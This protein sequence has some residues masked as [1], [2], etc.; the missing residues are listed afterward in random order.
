M[1]AKVDDLRFPS[2]NQQ[3]SKKNKL[4]QIVILWACKG[5]ALPLS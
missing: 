1:L 3:Q 2:E 5:D 4:R